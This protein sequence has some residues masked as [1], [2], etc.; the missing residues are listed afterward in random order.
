MSFTA[1][2]GT[3]ERM[4]TS[5]T[6][7]TQWVTRGTRRPR[8]ILH[9]PA[10][11]QQRAGDDKSLRASSIRQS[12]SRPSPFARFWHRLEPIWPSPSSC[13]PSVFVPSLHQ[14]SSAFASPPSWFILVTNQQLS[15]GRYA[16]APTITYSALVLIYWLVPT[17]CQPGSK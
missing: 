14:S 12:V 8:V 6:L 10:V 9:E 4:D 11:T 7:P 3:T 15:E 16:F 2:L 13:A 17:A 5:L 1:W